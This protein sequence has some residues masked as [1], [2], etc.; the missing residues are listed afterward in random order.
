MPHAI[1]RGKNGRR[2]EVD[3][4][5][6]PVRVEIY[7][8]EET[9]ETFIEADFEALPE[10]R[11]RFALINIPPPFQRGDRRRGATG[12]NPLL[13][14]VYLYWRAKGLCSLINTLE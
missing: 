14:D 2:D 7:S 13:T 10:E 4:G 9:V 11:R 5:N 12:R 3:L 1:I 6:A 8:S